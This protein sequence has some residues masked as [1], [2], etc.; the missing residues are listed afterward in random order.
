MPY[1]LYTEKVDIKNPVIQIYDSQLKLY[2][3]C[4]VSSHGNVR[5]F[6]STEHQAM[7]ENYPKKWK[8]RFGCHGCLND[9]N[10][11]ACTRA[12]NHRDADFKARMVHTL[13]PGCF[14]DCDE[15]TFQQICS[16]VGHNSGI[17][18]WLRTHW[19]ALEEFDGKPIKE[20]IA[21]IDRNCID[22]SL[23]KNGVFHSITPKDVVLEKDVRTAVPGQY[24]D[25]AHVRLAITDGGTFQSTAKWLQEHDKVAIR[26]SNK[27]LKMHLE[28]RKY[29]IPVNALKITEAILRRDRILEVT[30]EPKDIK[31][32]ED[33]KSDS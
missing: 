23:I 24:F 6:M 18:P 20:L 5:F 9:H 28:D 33:H 12:I 30:Y 19:Q 32:K 22:Y 13:F 3:V 14:E 17:R 7:N 29:D 4:Y 8:R 21:W 11:I 2:K 10:C 16:D 27:M 26:T 25:W 15:E 1:K 31:W